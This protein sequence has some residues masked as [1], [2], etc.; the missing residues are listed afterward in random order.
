MHRLEDSSKPLC[1]PKGK[2]VDKSG[3]SVMA[4]MVLEERAIAESVRY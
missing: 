2:C 4:S 3:L 1:S